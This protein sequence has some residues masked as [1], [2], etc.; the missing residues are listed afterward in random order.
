MLKKKFYLQAI[1]PL[2]LT[3]HTTKGYWDYIWQMKHPEV[4]NQEQK[5]VATIRNPDIIKRSLVDRGVFLY[6]RKIQDKYFCLVAK[7]LNGEGFL[8][9][10][11]IT[12][13]F[14]QGEIVW[15]KPKR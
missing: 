9:T 1:S 3:I 13:K 11:Y 5:A 4:K 15:Q 8:I 10:A 2:G 12:K 6:Y 14:V 7:H